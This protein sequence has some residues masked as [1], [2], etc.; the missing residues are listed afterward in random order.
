MTVGYY[1]DN[2]VSQSVMKAFSRRGVTV[3]HIRDFDNSKPGIFYGI[4][5][6]SGI[7]SRILKDRGIDFWYVDNGYFDAVYMN[8]GKLKDMHG[9]YRIVKNGYIDEVPDWFPID[10]RPFKKMRFLMLPP[11]TYSAFMHDTTPEDW[12]ITWGQKIHNLGHSRKTRDKTETVPL[13]TELENCDAVFAFNSIAVVKA[14]EMGK[15]VY[16]THGI[17]R[18]A[19]MLEQCAPYFNIN[20]IKN[21]YEPNQH[22][23]E[24]IADGSTRCLM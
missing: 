18:N 9:T 3:K 17:I 2:N 11:T 10:K 24:E 23:L 8:E 21:F 6:G 22:T 7:A 20:D 16:T 4:L 15:A 19:D 14:I 13:E 12:I 5:R 1:T